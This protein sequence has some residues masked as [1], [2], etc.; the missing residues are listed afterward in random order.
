MRAVNTLSPSVRATL[1]AAWFAQQLELPSSW[2]LGLRCY[3]LNEWKRLGSNEHA[4]SVL[5]GF[6][7][8]RLG[9]PLE[10]TADDT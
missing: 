10:S 2:E 5:E 4:W 1:L 6:T 9:M 3:L 8:A 7:A